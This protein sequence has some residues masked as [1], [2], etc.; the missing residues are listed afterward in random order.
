MKRKVQ[1]PSETVDIVHPDINIGTPRR[2]MGNL[3]IVGDAE[4]EIYVEEY[5]YVMG[6]GHMLAIPA[7]GRLFS[8]K[9][10]LL[11]Q[12]KTVASA[13]TNEDGSFAIEW[14]DP[15]VGYE[16]PWRTD[17]YLVD[18]TYQPATNL[19]P[20]SHFP[21][22]TAYRV[23]TLRWFDDV[24]TS[25]EDP[26]HERFPNPVP[27]IMFYGHEKEKDVGMLSGQVF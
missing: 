22:V 10:A 23:L 21:Q 7:N 20:L 17:V 9:R 8:G 2:V 26:P 25:E 3:N 27:T 19:P 14:R 13:M 4:V 15:P 18:E 6:E 12:G 5:W 1:N 16:R 24:V 11:E